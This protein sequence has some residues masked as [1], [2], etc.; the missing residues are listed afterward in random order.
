MSSLDTTHTRQSGSVPSGGKIIDTAGG[1]LIAPASA[2]NR[3]GFLAGSLA[4]ACGSS[5]TH[6][7]RPASVLAAET[8][9]AT[10]ESLVAA[11]HATLSPA[12]REKVCQSWDY[13][14]PKFGLLRTRVANNWN[15]NDTDLSSDF[16]TAEQKQLARDIFEKLIA[17]E[18][19]ERFHKQLEDDTGGFGHQQSFAILGEPGQGPSQFLLTGR[20]MTLRCD[21]NSADHVAFGGP[22]FYGH[23]AGGFNEEK[24]HPGN[25]FWSQAV[26]ANAVYEMLDGM[27]RKVALVEKTPRENAVGFRGT[28]LH[29]AERP[30]GIAV[31]D[32]TADQQ[33]ELSRVLGVLLEPFRGSDRQEVRE[34]LAKQGGLEGCRLLFYKDEDIGNDGVWDNWRLEGPAF[35]WHFRGAPHVHVWV[36]IADDP[37][38]PINA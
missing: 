24:D 26:A 7:V 36:N 23:D 38:I 29:T 15:C 2:I 37:S 3:R 19:H 30:Q 1:G 31:T 32:L 16:F 9:S 11:L 27:Q 17:P 6:L 4:A 14:H 5:L 12:Q 34:C 8:T 18:W 25:V 21:G 22:I 35:V 13:V 10:A 28:A 20:H 33:G